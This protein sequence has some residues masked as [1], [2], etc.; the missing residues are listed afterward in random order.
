MKRINFTKL[1]SDLTCAPRPVCT[2]A[3]C[4]HIFILFFFKKLLILKEEMHIS[5]LGYLLYHPKNGLQIRNQ[6]VEQKTTTP[7]PNQIFYNAAMVFL[8]AAPTHPPACL[9]QSDSTALPLIKAGLKRSIYSNCPPSTLKTMGSKRII[10]LPQAYYSV[11][12]PRHG[13]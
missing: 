2:H 9:P 12:L 5:M 10:H 3:Y 7:F 8:A 13:S 6:E 1:S 11:A 4:V